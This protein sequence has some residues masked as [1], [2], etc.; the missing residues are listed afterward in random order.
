M[1]F[2]FVFSSEIHELAFKSYC[3][4]PCW[5]TRFK[6]QDYLSQQ[7]FVLDTKANT[8]KYMHTIDIRFTVQDK[9]R[10]KRIQVH[11]TVSYL[12]SSFSPEFIDRGMKEFSTCSWFFPLFIWNLASTWWKQSVFCVQDIGVVTSNFPGLQNKW[13]PHQ[14]SSVLC[15]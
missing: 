9:C 11:V 7:K 2:T 5:F 14:P 13:R 15:D 8:Y 4:P 3:C 1:R 10:H 12:T 6:N